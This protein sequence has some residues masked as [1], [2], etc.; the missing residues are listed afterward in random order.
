MLEIS[1]TIVIV[2][3]CFSLRCNIEI[4]SSSWNLTIY[5]GSKPQGP[6]R[7]HKE[8]PLTDLDHQS[9]TNQKKDCTDNIKLLAPC[10]NPQPLSHSTSLGLL[11]VVLNHVGVRRLVAVCRLGRQVGGQVIGKRLIGRRAGLLRKKDDVSQLFH[12][13]SFAFPPHLYLV[14][15]AQ[16]QKNVARLDQGRVGVGVYQQWQLQKEQ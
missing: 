8:E 2:T 14:G 4:S 13:F 16:V 12:S 11:T 10:K 3:V 5:A 15:L 6:Q 7:S 9:E 1:D